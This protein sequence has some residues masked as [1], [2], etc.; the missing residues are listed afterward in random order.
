MAAKST[1][2]GAW[3]R[4]AFGGRRAPA[5]IPQVSAAGKDLFALS[6]EDAPGPRAIL[7]DPEIVSFVSPGPTPLIV[8]LGGYEGV[9]HLRLVERGE[10]IGYRRADLPEATAF[11]D[12]ELPDRDLALGP[13]TLE[14]SWPGAEGPTCFALEVSDAAEPPPTDA[15]LQALFE[16]ALQLAGR[17][18]GRWR[19]EA[20]RRLKQIE[21]RAPL[22]AVSVAGRVERAGE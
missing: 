9:A 15:P 13:L 1:P 3:V 5:S 4:G 21:R 17:D 2:I 7:L 18:A 22:S 20:Q 6:A 16:H 12:V 19:L 10:T 14:L 8:T 11:H